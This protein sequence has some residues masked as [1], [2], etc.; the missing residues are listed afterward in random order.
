M[1]FYKEG[2]L[3]EIV[4]KNDEAIA[5]TAAF[6]MGL[7][8]SA[9]GNPLLHICGSGN[10]FDFRS[11]GSQCL[12]HM[13]DVAPS[14]EVEF[15]NIILSA[16]Q[17]TVLATRSY[18]TQ[19][20]FW[21]C[22]FEDGGTAFVDALE[23]RESS[24]GELFFGEGA[25][26][27]DDNLKRLIQV[28]SIDHLFFPR[29]DNKELALLALSAQAVSLSYDIDST[30]LSEADIQSLNIV[31]KKLH[32]RIHYESE[33][34]PTESAL[35]FLRLLAEIGQFTELGV[36]FLFDGGGAGAPVPDCIAQQLITS[37]LANSLLDVL[38]LHFND[39]GWG[40]HLGTLFEGLKDHKGLRTIKANVGKDAFGPEFSYLRQLLSH[41]R[42]ITVT[43]V[44]GQIY[45]D[46][47]SIDEL[48][49]L[50]RFY[51][52]SVDL[53]V[54][55]PPER[56]SLVATALVKTASTDFQRSA[57]LLSNHVDALCDIVSL[58][59]LDEF[60]GEDPPLQPIHGTHL[61]RNREQ[62]ETNTETR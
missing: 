5:E 46:G 47:Q 2:P 30:F 39:S 13:L 55:P 40:T 35:S 58:A 9:E 10:R 36:I 14:R 60:G 15:N 26:F 57:L 38:D 25:Q 33:T 62:W 20:C 23:S 4:G 43:T 54:E 48:Y 19:F 18:P 29:L 31:T 32:L 8:Q 16:E 52:G 24:F 56:P 37:V 27:S 44:F 6:F 41:N 53:A 17:C 61:K 1:D 11:A 22:T 59:K 49:S 34:F 51:R 21:G 42:Y 12:S 7:K 28:H 3:I 45:S 50:N